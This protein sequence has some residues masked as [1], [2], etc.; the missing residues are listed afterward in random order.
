[1]RRSF[2]TAFSSQAEQFGVANNATKQ[3]D[4]ALLVNNAWAQMG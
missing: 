3:N 1:M 2:L 4:K